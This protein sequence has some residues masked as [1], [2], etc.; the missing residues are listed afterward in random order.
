VATAAG[1]LGAVSI[2]V[3]AAL[4]AS[5]ISSAVLHHVGLHDVAA[6]LV[7]LSAAFAVRAVLAW[8]GEV[9]ARRTSATVTSQLRRTMLRHALDLGPAWLA[10]ER[11]GELSVT[12]TRGIRSLDAYFG[13]YLPQALLAATVPVVVLAWIAAIDWPSAL[14][15]LTL[16]ASVPPLMVHFGR[17]ARKESERQWRRL[18]SLAGRYLELIQGLPTLRSLG[19]APRGRQEVAAATE[20]LRRST[21]ASL[22]VG[23]LSSLVLD[24]LAG[25]GVGLVAMVLGL[26]LLAGD[27]PLATALAVL[28]VAPEVWV[29]LRRA[30]AEFHAS[31]EG[32]AAAA[33]VLDIL[34]TPAGDG[35]AV[36]PAGGVAAVT[37]AEG[38]RDDAPVG[39][40]DGHAWRAV[41]PAAAPLRLTN[42]SVRYPSRQ[43]PALSDLSLEVAPGEHVVL[44]G[45]S[46]VGK[47]TVLAVVLRFV[48][49]SEGTLTVGTV[50][51]AG[52]SAELWR[53]HIGWVPQRAH[54]FRGTLADN[55]RL[56][57]TDA[58]ERAVRRAMQQAGLDELVSRL[59]DGPRTLVGEG[60]LGLSAG[61]RQRVALARAVLRDAPLILLDEPAAHLDPDDVTELRER[62]LPWID[63]RSVLVANHD[64]YPRIVGRID[65]RVELHEPR[66]AAGG[67]VVEDGSVGGRRPPELTVSSPQ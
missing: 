59:P 9:T 33:R 5:I 8:V 30:A 58:P 50:D 40:V 1:I 14:L 65:R 63:G 7:G 62:L 42:V 2:V 44:H 36:T 66:R 54:L 20:G 35:A 51:L 12:A 23:F 52:V 56:A 41:D 28:L 46:G 21:L 17:R 43:R 64:A 6:R 57:R 38:G 55:V 18:G 39:G 61:E 32:K 48:A 67:G 10:T 24:M 3:Q 26:R 13:R 47:S 60:G 11:S 19:R 15:L 16:F 37:P 27:L 49:C 45:A 31:A 29:P 25:L 34:D 4:L 53:R 22:R